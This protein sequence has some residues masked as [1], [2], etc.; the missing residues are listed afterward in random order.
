MSPMGLLVDR[1][2]SEDRRA[3]PTGRHTRPSA[4]GPRVGGRPRKDERHACLVAVQ[5]RERPWNKPPGPVRGTEEVLQGSPGA[6]PGT[7]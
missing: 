3:D 1:S 2:C 7:T 6:I 5:E 4:R